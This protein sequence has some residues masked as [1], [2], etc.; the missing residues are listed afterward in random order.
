VST[1]TQGCTSHTNKDK[2]M[3]FNEIEWIVAKKEELPENATLE[4]HMCFVCL[5]N[6]YTDHYNKRISQKDASKRKRAIKQQFLAAVDRHNRYA[7]GYA[8]YQENIRKAGT[9]R[10]EILKDV[11]KDEDLRAIAFKMAQCIGAMCED[12][13][14]VKVVQDKLEM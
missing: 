13:V 10:A 4:E 1:V 8:Q 14:F 2:T 3:K 7:A 6:L 11:R 9:Y 12:E 5:K